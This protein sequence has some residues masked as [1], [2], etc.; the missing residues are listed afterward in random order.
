M[1]LRILIASLAIGVSACSGLIDEFPTTPDPVITTDTFT[2]TLTVNGS[3]THAVFTGATGSVVA[4][5]T[6]LGEEPPSKVGFSMGTLSVAGTCTVI[7]R[8]DNA[9]V[10]TALNGTVSTLQGSLCVSIYDTGA[11]AG[12][13]DYSFTVSH[14]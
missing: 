2:G 11:M 7:L 9:V 5:V 10:S 12:P 8:N 1:I 4:T 14:P 6:S 13:L 3:Q